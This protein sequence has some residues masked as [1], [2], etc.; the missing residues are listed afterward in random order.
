M[1]DRDADVRLRCEME[2]GLGPN[3]VEEVVERVAD[4]ADVQDRAATHVLSRAVDERVDD[5]H[6]VAARDERVDHVRADEA[7]SSGHDCPH[8]RILRTAIGCRRCS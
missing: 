6:L 2:H 5:G 3:L 7:G 1:L 4:V 8:D